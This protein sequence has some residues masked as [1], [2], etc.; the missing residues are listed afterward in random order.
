MSSGNIGIVWNSWLSTYY[1]VRNWCLNQDAVKKDSGYVKVEISVRD[2]ALKTKFA[3]RDTET[4]I[5]ETQVHNS[6]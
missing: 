5:R 1:T 2:S 6:H 4:L 3:E